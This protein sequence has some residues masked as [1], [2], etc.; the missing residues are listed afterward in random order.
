MKSHE[1]KNRDKK[2]R[3]RRDRRQGRMKIMLMK[4]MLKHGRDD[5]LRWRETGIDF[6]KSRIRLQWY[7]I[8][9]EVKQTNFNVI[10]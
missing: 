6:K 8:T 3:K 5:Q 4:I 9:V 1:S 10:R 7:L 2:K